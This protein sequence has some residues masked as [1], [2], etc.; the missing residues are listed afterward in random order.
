MDLG[1]D[2]TQTMIRDSAREF[3]ETS[4]GSDFVREMEADPRGF[5]DELW[6]SMADMGWIGMNVPEEHGGAGMGLVELALVLE[7]MGAAALPGPFFSTAVVGA[8]LL[9][10]HGSSAQKAELLPKLAQGDLITAF[11]LH[12]KRPAWTAGSISLRAEKTEDGWRLTGEK[13]FVADAHVADL[14]IVAART[15]T[16]P[17]APPEKSITLFL[18]KRASTDGISLTPLK[19]VTDDRLHAV[20]FREAVV[21]P[22]AM[23]GAEG[24]GWPA[25]QALFAVGATAKCAEMLGG[26][27]RV[28]DMTVEYVKDRVQFGRPVATFQAVQHRCADMATEVQAARQLTYQAAWR[29]AQGLDAAREVAIA[30]SWLSDIFPRVCAEAHQAHGA[31]GFTR[32]HDLQI[33]TRRAAAARLAYG[34][35]RHY[36]ETIAESMG[37]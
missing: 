27:R 19:S 13:L 31:I 16:E 35:A 9:T 3:L 14:F 12:E 24:G 20:E 32:E 28:L 8:T 37:L 18:V 7:E 22:D 34:D 5:S 26:S 15:D 11:A 21:P 25:L 10:T 33:Y 23:L 17:P 36:R 4:A 6:R 1:L 29:L 2:E 30:K